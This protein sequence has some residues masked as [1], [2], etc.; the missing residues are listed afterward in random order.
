M[1]YADLVRE[2]AGNTGHSQ[3]AVKEVLKQLA[4]TVSYAL[5]NGDEVPLQGI[6]KL[7]V[8]HRKAR[9]G[10][11]PREN[12]A[13]TIAARNTVFLKTTKSLLDVV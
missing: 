5:R 2:I 9:V 12:T 13:I 11:N 1:I 6:G 8:R 7:C 3:V 10:R 4:Q